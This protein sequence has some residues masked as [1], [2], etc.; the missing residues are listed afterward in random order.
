MAA[1][2]ATTAASR[3][4]PLYYALAQGGRAVAA[5]YAPQSSLHGHGIRVPVL[6]KDPLATRVEPLTSGEFPAIATLTGS[7]A[8]TAPVEVGALWAALPE[9]SLTADGERW[10]PA[11]RVMPNHETHELAVIQGVVD[12]VVP[13]DPVPQSRQELSAFLA[14]YPTLNQGWE[15]LTAVSGEFLTR[16]TSRGFGVLLRTTGEKR[17]VAE[18]NR[19]LDSVAPEYRHHDARWLRPALGPKDDQ[20][21]PLMTWW[22]LLYAFSVFARYHPA[23]WTRLLD[24]DRSELAAPVEHALDE[25]LAAVPHLLLEAIYAEPVLL[26]T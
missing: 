5:A 12:L 2:A 11:L 26:A 17:N 21:S 16:A 14:H 25:A 18:Q 23:E 13:V 1:A 15:V 7:N 8:L 9:L 4:L 22:A 20:L 3:P 10:P 19:V 6:E 24:L